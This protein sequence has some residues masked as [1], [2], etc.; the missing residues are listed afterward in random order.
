MADLI[1]RVDDLGRECGSRA[2]PPLPLPRERVGHAVILAST[3]RVVDRARPQADLPGLLSRLGR[4]LAHVLRSMASSSR[5]PVRA[6]RLDGS[7]FA[8]L[9]RPEGVLAAVAVA[10]CRA[11]RCLLAV[12]AWW[13]GRPGAGFE[14]VLSNL[15]ARGGRC[16]RHQHCAEDPHVVRRPAW[17]GAPDLQASCCHLPG[18]SLRLPRPEQLARGDLLSRREDPPGQQG[19][20]VSGI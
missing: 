1:D 14:C 3:A 19:I 20:G 5:T 13:A 8:Y 11:F 17:R 7:T 12:R 15:T 6:R 18:R 4:Q 10:C 9:C 16:D 2:P